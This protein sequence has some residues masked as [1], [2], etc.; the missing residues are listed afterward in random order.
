MSNLVPKY[1]IWEALNTS[2][3]LG[4]RALDE[5]RTLARTPGPPGEPG[6]GFDDLSFEQID[7]RNFVL[8]FV[9]GKQVKEFPMRVDAM[10]YRDVFKEGDTYQA[11]DAVTWGGCVWV[12]KSDTKAKPGTCDEWRLAVKKG[13]DGKD[14]SSIKR[15]PAKPFK[16]NGGTDG[17]DYN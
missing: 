17:A 8:R 7:H 16:L 2:L 5:I 10:I 6:L 4:R 1:S 14:Y 9:R 13:R 3:A 12:A 11:G 15:D